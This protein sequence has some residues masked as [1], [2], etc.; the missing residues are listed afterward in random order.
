MDDLINREI[1]NRA[2]I[3]V[4]DIVFDTIY[5]QRGTVIRIENQPH[6]GGTIYFVQHAHQVEIPRYRREI[7]RVP[8]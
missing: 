8:Q 3:E 6:Y 7:V 1:A 5:N 2:E 4:G